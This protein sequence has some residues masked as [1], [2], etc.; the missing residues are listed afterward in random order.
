MLVH[1]QFRT[2]LLWLIKTIKKQFKSENNFKN[3]NVAMETKKSLVKIQTKAKQK[4]IK[5][6]KN[7][8][9]KKLKKLMKPEN[10]K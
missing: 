9:I 1:D 2:D 4:Y 3:G 5:L 6:T 10:V 7:T 8:F